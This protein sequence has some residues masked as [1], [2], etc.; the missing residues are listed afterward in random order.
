MQFELMF[1]VFYTFSS[2]GTSFNS[3]LL[4]YL[5][6]SH[7]LVGKRFIEK[8][9]KEFEIGDRISYD[10]VSNVGTYIWI[11]KGTWK[12]NLIDVGYG[13][14]PFLSLLL[15]IVSAVNERSYS[16]KK[17]IDLQ[18]L[19]N[20]FGIIENTIVIEEPEINLHPKLQSKLAD[21]F[22][23]AHETFNVNFIIETHSEYLIRKFQYLTAKGDLE[24]DDTVL[25]YIGNSEASKRQQ[26]KQQV[27]TIHI[28]PNG[29]LTEPF[30]SG[31]TDESSRWIKEMFVLP[32]Q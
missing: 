8:W 4:K 24:T 14:T 2:Q 3:I 1:N 27:R 22:W 21:F 11:Q 30:G 15:N 28:K 12:V 6:Q 23:D 10:R 5:K 29:Q 19:S 9:I 18:N 7:T 32:N 26:D 31:F 13:V 16:S 20:S 25:H 17:N